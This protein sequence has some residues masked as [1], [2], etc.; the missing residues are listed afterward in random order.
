MDDVTTSTNALA[1]SAILSYVF[2]GRATVTLVSEKTQAHF[3][4]RVQAAQDKQDPE[5][6]IYFVHYLAGPDNQNSY[7]YLGMVPTANSPKLV[8]TKKSGAG[9]EATVTRAFQFMLAHPDAATLR[10]L[11]SGRCG[12]CGR[13]LTTPESITTGLGPICK[14]K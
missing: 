3:T 4:Y 8:L 9:P 11:H 10:V 7:A 6:T 1:A 14:S 13:A 5:R 12:R 2:A